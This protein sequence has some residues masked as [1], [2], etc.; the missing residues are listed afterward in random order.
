MG[1]YNSTLTETERPDNSE[2]DS[3]A[4]SVAILYDTCVYEI[5]RLHGTMNINAGFLWNLTPYFVACM[6]QRF[7]VLLLLIFPPPS[8]LPS[9]SLFFLPLLLLFIILP[10]LPLRW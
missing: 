9:S 1:N 7:E 10:L 5:R 3:N 2:Q 4:E 6:Y 8:P